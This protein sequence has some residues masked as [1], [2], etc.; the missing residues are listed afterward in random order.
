MKGEL[1]GE[2]KRKLKRK[3]NGKLK[4]AIIM[5]QKRAA[6]AG[7][8]LVLLLGSLNYSVGISL[9]TFLLPTRA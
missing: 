1:N 8:P 5:I 7:S 2:L 4:L 3:L 6:L 9:L